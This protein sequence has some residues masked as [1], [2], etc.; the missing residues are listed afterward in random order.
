MDAEPTAERRPSGLQ[1]TIDML[2]APRQACAHLRETPTWGWAFLIAVVF[3]MLAS[4]ALVPALHHAI[5][6][7]LPAQIA[8]TPSIAKLPPAEQQKA[9]ARIVAVQSIA[10][11]VTWLASLVIV[12]IIALVQTLVMLVASRLGGGD[13]TFRRLWALA[14][15]VQVAGSIG[16][17]ILAAIVLLRGPASFTDPAQ[18]QAVLPNLGTIVPGAP[19]VIG[20][21]LGALNVAA[22]WQ[23]A[24][25][26]TGMIV[27]ARAARP[28]AW[29]AA[30]VM[31]LSLGV[32]AAIGA[33]ARPHA[34]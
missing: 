10:L 33:A 13:G 4:L 24:L 29:S 34:G 1:T 25:L 14:L 17:L 28:A 7:S 30:A 23:A 12:P 9:V 27:T 6:A 22:I 19:R 3:G 21:F 15:N 26:G 5:E 20:A 32:F 18:I 8:A 11:N 16:G 31:L 2:V